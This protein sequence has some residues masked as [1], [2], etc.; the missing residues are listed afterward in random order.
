MIASL[1]EEYRVLI[2]LSYFQGLPMRDCKIS[3]YPAGNSEDE[4]PGGPN[5]I[6]NKHELTWI[7]GEYISNLSLKAMCW[8]CFGRKSAEL[9]AFVGSFRNWWLPGT[10]LKPGPPARQEAVA[11][12]LTPPAR[13]RGE[14][15]EKLPPKT[16][17]SAE[18]RIVPAGYP[19]ALAE[20]LEL[21]RCGRRSAP[22]CQQLAIFD[23]YERNLKLE[24]STTR[25]QVQIDSLTGHWL[26]TTK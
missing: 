22:G 17:K 25:F 13:V 2:D 15:L 5:P 23:L 11:H 4:D 18:A 16:G 12:A 7:S 21:C 8:T 6:K 14:V 3:E 9:S 19:N 1:K 10:N 20:P 26:L 24:Q